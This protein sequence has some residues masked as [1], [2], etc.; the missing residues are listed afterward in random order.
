MQ[1]CAQGSTG[2]S[3]AVA[4]PPP[5]VPV[6]EFSGVGVA[7]AGVVV[8]AQVSGGGSLAATALRIS[9]ASSLGRQLQ[10]GSMVSQGI[11]VPSGFRQGVGVGAAVSVGVGPSVG[12]EVVSGVGVADGPAVGVYSG[13]GVGVTTTEVGHGT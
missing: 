8:G 1:G 6:G 3:V 9:S 12:V 10:Q 11:T 2:V 7:P 13:V 4:E 5:D